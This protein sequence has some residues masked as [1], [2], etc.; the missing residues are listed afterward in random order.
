[1]KTS[2]IKDLTDEELQASF[3]ERTRELFNLRVQQT[4]GQLENPLRVRSVRREIARIKT[5][6]NNRARNGATV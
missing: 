4:T 5:I 1:M 6:M 2:E 3:E